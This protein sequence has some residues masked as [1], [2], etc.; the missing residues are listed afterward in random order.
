VELSVGALDLAYG[1]GLA[2]AT[3]LQ[4]DGFGIAAFVHE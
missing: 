4:G 3:Q 1:H 2:P